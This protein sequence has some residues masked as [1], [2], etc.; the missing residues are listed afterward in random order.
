M[1]IWNVEKEW[2]DRRINT[3]PFANI[4]SWSLFLNYSYAIWHALC[5]LAFFLTKKEFRW[6]PRLQVEKFCK[7]IFRTFLMAA[8]VTKILLKSYQR[9]FKRKEN[10][11]LIEHKSSN[12]I[13]RLPAPPITKQIRDVFFSVSSYGSELHDST[14]QSRSV[15]REFFFFSLQKVYVPCKRWQQQT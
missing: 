2:E 4:N 3:I 13:S 6:R 15:Q 11:W 9:S 12:Q 14:W 7:E 10:K 8:L 5:Q 1:Q